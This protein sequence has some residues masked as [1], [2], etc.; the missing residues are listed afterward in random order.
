VPSVLRRRGPFVLEL[1]QTSQR[2]LFQRVRVA[3]N[4]ELAIAL[5]MG[6]PPIQCLDELSQMADEFRIRSGVFDDHDVTA[7]CQRGRSR[8]EARPAMVH[9]CSQTRHRQYVVTV[10]VFARVSTSRLLQN[11]H[12]LGRTTVARLS[13]RRSSVMSDSISV[14]GHPRVRPTVHGGIRGIC[15]L[16][17]RSPDQARFPGGAVNNC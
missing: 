4:L 2:E 3:G 8:D 6:H 10:T 1:L 5:D 16:L 7:R 17:H 13:V 15:S 11:G 14:D 12:T 9:V